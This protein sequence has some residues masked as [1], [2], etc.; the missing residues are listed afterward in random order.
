MSNEQDTILV[1]EDDRVLTVTLNR[2]EKHNATTLAMSERMYAEIRAADERQ[3]VGCIVIKGAG[4]SFSSGAD[5]VED[6]ERGQ[7]PKLHSDYDRPLDIELRRI[8]R[9]AEGSSGSLISLL[10]PIIAQV[11]GYCLAGALDVASNCD[12]IVA[13]EDAQIGY[14]ITRN[15]ASPPTHMFTYLMGTQWTRYMFYTGNLIDGK[16]AAEVGLALLAVPREELDSVVSELAHRIAS[17]PK[18]L[19]VLHKMI[20]NKALDLMG[21]PTLQLLARE[22]DMLAHKTPSMKAFHEAARQGGFKAGY[23]SLEKRG[24]ARS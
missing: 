3:D 20:C 23:D 14:P 1:S 12:L 17:V 13:A 7:D 22:T 2:P 6:V 4:P 19:L 16:K 10:T 15:I 11:H 18:D 8:S 21:R 5:M 24:A 9:S